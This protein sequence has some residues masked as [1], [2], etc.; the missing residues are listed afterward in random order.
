M[1]ARIEAV[2]FWSPHHLLINRIG[3]TVAWWIIVGWRIAARTIWIRTIAPIVTWNIDEI[4]NYWKFK[5][6]IH[7]FS[8][9]LVISAVVG[10]WFFH[11]TK[12]YGLNPAKELLKILG[13]GLYFTEVLEFLISFTWWTRPKPSFDP[14]PRIG[15][16]VS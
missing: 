7:I 10:Y 5:G 11:M 13:T 2:L 3:E 9:L 4:K 1:T 12:K 8:Y 15:L 16:Y 14:W 6:M